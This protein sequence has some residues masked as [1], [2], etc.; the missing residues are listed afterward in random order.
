MLS[1]SGV[2]KRLL[3]RLQRV[4]NKAA[5]VVTRTNRYDHISPV[6][7]RLHWLPVTQRV[8]YKVLTTTYR[9]LNEDAPAYIKDMLKV[10][11]P[12]RALRSNS[13]TLLHVPRS[14]TVRYGN[15]AFATAAPT[16]WNKLPID[17]RI[18]E[19]LASFRSKLKNISPLAFF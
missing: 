3:Q 19:S 5:R 15:R 13:A 14:R 4:Q 8:Q 2:P 11:Q 18:C 12:V 10:N 9:A 7:K 1:L 16:L 17:I 6:L